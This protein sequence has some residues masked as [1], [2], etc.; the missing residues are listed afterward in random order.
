MGD[1]RPGRVDRQLLAR[2]LEDEGAESI[3]R[4]KLVQPGARTEVLPRVNQACEHRVRVP[5]E[6]PRLAIGDR[7]APAGRSFHAHALSLLS[8]GSSAKTRARGQQE[9]GRGEGTKESASVSAGAPSTLRRCRGRKTAAATSPIA[10]NAPATTKPPL[11]PWVSATGRGEPES[12]ALV[13]RLVETAERI[14]GPSEPPTRSAAFSTP[15]PSPPP[16][17]RPP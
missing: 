16:P 4:R 7:G 3:E 15:P 14:A 12:S 9:G 17:G 5:K 1:D 11:K 13:K 2:D 8:L 10:Q 6:L